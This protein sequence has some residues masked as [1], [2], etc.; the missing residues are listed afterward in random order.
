MSEPTVTPGP[1]Q[2]R[3]LFWQQPLKKGALMQGATIGGREDTK[4][5]YF[6]KFLAVKYFEIDAIYHGSRNGTLY[7]GLQ[8]S[9]T[10]RL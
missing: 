8:D 4:S 2:L 7:A 3:P 10:L 9:E 1:I 6:G 5:S